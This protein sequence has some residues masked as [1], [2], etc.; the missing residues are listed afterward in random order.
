MS[1]AIGMCT[2]VFRCPDY[3]AHAVQGQATRERS[4]APGTV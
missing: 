4:L 2:V 1:A 3:L